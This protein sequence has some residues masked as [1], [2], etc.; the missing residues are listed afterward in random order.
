MKRSAKRFLLISFVFFSFWNVNAQTIPLGTPIIENYFRRQQLLGNFDSLYSFNFRPITLSEN[1]LNIDSAVF[2]K[3]DY[4]GNRIGL[5]KNKAGLRLLPIEKRSSF[6]SHHPDSRN[7]G[8]QIRARGLQSYISAGFSFD[9]GMLSIQVKPEFVHA[10]NREYFGFPTSH[11]GN[12]IED[13]FVYFN[14]L[15]EPERYGEGAYDRITPGQSS[16]RLNKWGL[17][18]GLST[19]NLWWG[20]GIR[21]SIH[22]SNNAQGFPHL[23]FNTQRPVKTKI[24]SFEWQFITGKLTSS[25]FDPPEELVQRVD[26]GSKQYRPK[27]DD[28][29]YFQAISLSYS[30]KW[31]KGL[32]LGVTRWVQQYSEDTKSSNDYLPVFSKLFKQ[33]STDQYGTS[34]QQDQASGIFGRWIWFDTQSELY[35]EFAKKGTALNFQ[36][37]IIGTDHAKAFTIGFHKLIPT[38]DKE[39]F[40]QLNFEATQTSQSE[41]RLF[42]NTISWYIHPKVRDGFTNN[43]EILGSALG[44][45]GNAQYVG[46]SWV[47]GLKRIGA[48]VER[49]IHN[50][51]FFSFAFDRTIDFTRRWVD[52]T[53]QGYIDWRFKSV[54]LSGTVSYTK[55]YNYQWELRRINS[56]PPFKFEPGEDEDNF[57]VDIR[58]A[59]IL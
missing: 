20:P 31:I 23:T 58:I 38:I 42:R 29:R 37:L 39:A 28:W 16:I 55:S 34:L 17:S 22:L 19:E 5:F 47:K 9:W 50:S 32:S 30:P 15:D 3:D 35:F 36:D 53:L 8:A 59:Y 6:D 46:L 56:T 43:G 14:Q 12:V 2:N 21:N 54:L 27:P 11:F 44:P 41:T 24:G 26:R 10:E 49:R 45:G 1:G 52:Y 33:N 18:L 4:F 57:S 51:D 40:M 7:D 48:S 25:G 13:R